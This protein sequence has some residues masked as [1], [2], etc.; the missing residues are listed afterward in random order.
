M[1]PA[2]NAGRYIAQAVDSV[3]A[4]TFLDWELI[5]IDDGSTDD[6]AQVLA[7]YSDPR[8][9][10]FH[11]ANSGEAAARNAALDRA[12][13]KYL[14][15]LDADDVF[16][17]DHLE[18]AA[19]FFQANPGYDGL[20]TDGYYINQDGQRLK[21]LSARRRGPFEGDIFEQVM[22]SSD[23]F[24]APVCVFLTRQVIVQAALRFD[25]EI[26]IG[27]DWDFLTQ[28]AEK[29]RFGYSPKTT[30]LYR[31]HTTNIS[32]RTNLEKRTRSLA[33]CREKTIH[34]ARFGECS[35]EARFFV[36]YDLMVNL[37]KADQDRRDEIVRWPEFQA[38]PTT[39]QAQLVRHMAVDLLVSGQNSA[40]AGDWL[41]LALELDPTETRTRFLSSLYR[42]S[43][44]LCETVLRF[45]KGGKEDQGPVSPFADLFQP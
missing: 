27:P 45:R 4:Q 10:I 14:A 28:Y 7:C 43:P 32:L 35:P 40:L 6:T 34:M 12:S 42:V 25:L 33:R 19:A 16:L 29:G 5:V 23:V 30:C 9:Q 38:L 31:V 20:Y 3:L 41:R 2:Y 36:F 13:G 15:F 18:T 24:G 11:Q 17:P 37:L 21:P 22:R 26:I 1:M 39:L 8:I 44:R